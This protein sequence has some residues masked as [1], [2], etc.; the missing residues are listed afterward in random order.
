MRRRLT[1]KNMGSGN[2]EEGKSSDLAQRILR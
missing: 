2:E 1:G